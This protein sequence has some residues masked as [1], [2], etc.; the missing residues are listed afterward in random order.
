ME[1]SECSS[2][3]FNDPDGMTVDEAGNIVV[4]D[5]CNQDIRMVSAARLACQLGVWWPSERGILCDTDTW[6]QWLRAR[7]SILS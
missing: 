7:C 4:V 2:A 3:C 1:D 5:F 6:G